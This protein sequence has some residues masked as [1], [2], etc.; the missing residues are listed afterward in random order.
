MRLSIDVAKTV[1][2]YTTAISSLITVVDAVSEMSEDGRII[3]QASCAGF[4][5]TSLGIYRADSRA[6]RAG[7]C[8]RPVHAAGVSAVHAGAGSERRVCRDVQAVCNDC[9]SR[10][11]DQRA[12]GPGYKTN[13]CECGNWPTNSPFE[14]KMATVT[15]QQWFEA[16][17][18][19]VD[20][21]NGAEHRLVD[22]FMATV[23]AAASEARW[24][25]WTLLMVA[26]GLLVVTG[27]VSMF[28]VLSITRP[29]GQLVRND[30]DARRR[31]SRHRGAGHR[32]W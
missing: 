13:S 30:D 24:G 10:V 1:E 8:G 18:R 17:T 14:N 4:T 15:G 7:L 29:V 19:Y 2:F 3:R 5:H 11:C 20:A 12:S 9:A 22:D 31:P 23:K 26:L 6:G 21:L 27:A 25:F 28:V 32:P 16:A